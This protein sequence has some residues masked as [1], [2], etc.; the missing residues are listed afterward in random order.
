MSR[1]LSKRERNALILR[2]R[3]YDYAK[4]S[5][6]RTQLQAALQKVK[7]GLPAKIPIVV[8]GAVVSWA[9]QVRVQSQGD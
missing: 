4:N 2:L 8:N 7:S 5:P 1:L 6:E 9:E 3:Q